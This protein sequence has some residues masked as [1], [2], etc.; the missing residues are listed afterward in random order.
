MWERIGAGRLGSGD[1]SSVTCLV[2]QPGILVSFLLVGERN[3][4][5][6]VGAAS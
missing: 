4:V 5:A 3:G 6:A 1:S 2:S